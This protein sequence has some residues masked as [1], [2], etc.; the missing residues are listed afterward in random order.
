MPKKENTT[1]EK[2]FKELESGGATENE[3]VDTN[4]GKK[5]YYRE[6]EEETELGKKGLYKKE[7]PR[8]DVPHLRENPVTIIILL[9]AISAIGYFVFFYT[10][11]VA[12]GSF[13]VLVFSGEAR[14]PNARVE[15]YDGATL[16]ATATTDASGRATFTGLP[17]KLLR[18]SISTHSGTINRNINP[19]GRRIVTLNLANEGVALDTLTLTVLDS[20]TREPV[21][22]VKVSY[23]LGS[24]S[25]RWFSESNQEGKATLELQGETIVRIHV[26]DPQRR[27]APAR[28]SLLADKDAQPILLKRLESQPITSVNET[29]SVE[30]IARSEEGEE[31]QSGTVTVF[32]AFTGSE[33]FG[34]TEIQNSRAIV[35]G[36]S[37]DSLVTFTVQAPGFYPSQATE[38]MVTSG[39]QPVS[40]TLQRVPQQ[41]PR[42]IVKLSSEEMPVNG[43]VHVFQN[44]NLSS[45]I[46]TVS[47]NGTAEFALA[48]GSYYALVISEGYISFTTHEFQAGE[49]VNVRL[50]RVSSETAVELE[51]NVNDEEGASV[52]GASVAIL[53]EDGLL[54]ALPV[55]TQFAVP[56]VFTLPVNSRV[57]ARAMLLQ[58]QAEERVELLQDTSITL[59]L[60]VHAAYIALTVK[61]LEDN[62]PVD[63]ALTSYTQGK[64]YATCSG[65]G[66]CRIAVNG[67]SDVAVDVSA[68][69]FL[70][71]TFYAP[72]MREGAQ[73]S[74]E[75]RLVPS[76]AASQVNAELLEIIDENGNAVSGRV[77][78]RGVVYTARFY[79]SGKDAE[80]LSLYV[81]VD[82]STRQNAS[83]STVHLLEPISSDFVDVAKS[84]IYVGPSSQCL[85]L[86]TPVFEPPFKWVELTFVNTS[87]QQVDIPFEI[88]PTVADNA[89]FR[90]EYR[91]KVVK[92]NVHA[93][94]PADNVL[95]FASSSPQKA[96]C[97]ADTTAVAFTVSVDRAP[98]I[99]NAFPVVEGKFTSGD[100]LVFDPA[101]R[102][103]RSQNGLTNYELQVDSIL[104]GDAMPLA[105]QADSQCVVLVRE[106]NT[107]SSDPVASCYRYDQARGVLVFEAR[108]LNPLC[109]IHLKDDKFYAASGARIT[110]HAVN[111][112]VL[113]SCA[114][115]AKLEIPI[116]VN[117]V[118]QLSS[119]TVRPDASNL[120]EGDAAKL[121]YL[122]NNRQ[123]QRRNIQAQ[124]GT[125]KTYQLAGPSAK[126][127]AWR[128]PGS[129]EFSENGDLVQELIFQDTSRAFKPG[130]GVLSHRQ[131]TC[132]TNDVFCCADGWCTRS[133]LEAMVST[134]K[135]TS[136]RVASS[137]AFRRGN[138]QPFTYFSTQP[139]KFVTA[140][141]ATQG[142]QQALTVQGVNFNKPIS[143]LPGNPGVYELAA[144][145]SSGKEDEWN[146]TAKV[147][148]LKQAD[149]IQAAS[150]CGGGSNATQAS[151]TSS[152]GE[153]TLC[154]FLSPKNNCIESTRNAMINSIDQLEKLN[155]EL[156][157]C[158]YPVFPSAPVCPG[159]KM[160][161]PAVNIGNYKTQADFNPADSPNAF[162]KIWSSISDANASSFSVFSW[163]G[164]LKCIVP[165]S[166]QQFAISAAASGLDLTDLAAQEAN[167]RAPQPIHSDVCSRQDF[168][169]LGVIP[170][171]DTV[172][173]LAGVCCPS[174]V[175][176]QICTSRRGKFFISVQANVIKVITQWGLTESCYPYW[177]FPTTPQGL[178]Q[179]QNVVSAGF[180]LAQY[181]SSNGADF[182]LSLASE[183]PGEAPAVTSGL[184]NKQCNGDG[185]CAAYQQCAVNE[186]YAYSGGKCVG[187][188][189]SSPGVCSY[190]SVSEAQ[191]CTGGQQCKQEGNTASCKSCGG[192]GE[193]CCVRDDGN[194]FCKQGAGCIVTGATAVCTSSCGGENQPVCGGWDSTATCNAGLKLKP[195]SGDRLYSICSST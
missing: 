99:E 168:F 163:Q 121:L 123:L 41:A 155:F 100:A 86:S 97:Y 116:S 72:A 50:T 66:G 20:L 29:T 53:N 77:L 89:M 10:P 113:A 186:I 56:A 195:P 129:L 44:G 48:E 47:T 136:S 90:L 118:S 184:S 39:M 58:A 73:S 30:V 5:G 105:L 122:I 192:D 106:P 92:G 26:V 4:L 91:A 111:L 119:L 171:F 81:R 38:V 19:G 162:Q 9:L 6:K 178:L 159:T 25:T 65:Y 45:L 7:T 83:I 194:A 60:L 139:F 182:E 161:L 64:I 103:L 173:P 132:A 27:Y 147:L 76:S 80:Q 57:K 114:P 69:G 62:A 179:K 87:S 85:D 125:T 32:Y 172:I 55:E 40:I 140:V 14:F 152:T 96:N 185:D 52:I 153:A 127:L 134:F 117:F 2:K 95:G 42:T 59:S 190:A 17:A 70:P 75:V 67:D 128:G 35:S 126:P 157:N 191:A 110:R 88:P 149:Y 141:Q 22:G 160:V 94:F 181:L 79:A 188:S 120:G 61:N 31:I 28:L 24:N 112:T 11:P 165:P 154:N 137:T 46:S 36:I 15:V 170:N 21:S 175:T 166:F 8:L 108:E 130:T 98:V 34:S 138:G 37:V 146:Y 133:A 82:G 142:S 74:A 145:S 144:V 109:P 104:P 180:G 169:N 101:Q 164:Q 51:V 3:T 156:V 115:E 193:A 174:S 84:S 93:R 78:R 177:P 71:Y 176:A 151:L 167:E 102:T 12:S 63:V 16:I 54:A 1:L 131:T 33:A 43:M 107:T 143:C 189:T 18:F 23:A 135:E 13:N 187:K 148:E 158:M 150:G 49:E 124:F 183:T 68:V